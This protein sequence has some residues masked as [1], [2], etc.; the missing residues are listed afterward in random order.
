MNGAIRV[1]NNIGRQESRRREREKREEE[2]DARA[3]ERRAGVDEGACTPG[4]ARESKRSGRRA[5]PST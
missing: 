2:K 5:S 3:G 4:V 1:T